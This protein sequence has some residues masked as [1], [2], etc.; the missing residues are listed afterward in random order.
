VTPSRSPTV[1]HHGV[2][3]SVHEYVSLVPRE[4][5][6]ED[7]TPMAPVL[8]DT[9]PDRARATLPAHVGVTMLDGVPE[10]AVTTVP[11]RPRPVV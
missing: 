7:E 9:S 11:T 6:E 5:T 2:G 3:T 8:I 1:C 10:F 4:I